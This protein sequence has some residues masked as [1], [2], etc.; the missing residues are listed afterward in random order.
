MRSPLALSTRP[1]TAPSTSLFFAARVNR[2]VCM[3][4]SRSRSKT[5]PSSSIAPASRKAWRRLGPEALDVEGP[6]AGDV[7]DPV[8]QL[9]RALAVVGAAEVLVA[10]LL[11]QRARC[12]T[13]RHSVGITHSCA[14]SGR[15]AEH[16]AQDL[17][18]HVS[19]LA[20]DHCVA[21]PD[22]L[23]PSPRGRCAA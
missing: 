21:G 11:L 9:R 7:E 18:D 3:S 22:V 4:L 10:L 16:R 14:S 13:A 8:E 20:Q 17:G 19:G 1:S 5:S 12:R 2:S 6:P 15:R 23:A